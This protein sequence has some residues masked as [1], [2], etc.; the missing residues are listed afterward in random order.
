[1][2]RSPRNAWGTSAPPTSTRLRVPSPPWVKPRAALREWEREN[3][4]S[5]T[6]DVTVVGSGPNGL[7]A[8][9]TAARAGLSV[10]VLEASD[11]VGGGL[12]TAELT[13]PGFRHDVCS[14]VHPAVAS[15]P[16]F[17][18]TGIADRVEWVVPEAS[19][20]HPFDDGSAGIAWR[21]L[22]RTADALGRDGAAWRRMLA[23]LARDIDGVVDFTGNPL[24]R[25]PRHPV[26]A[27]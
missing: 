12:R 13:L 14:A 26:T 17:R 22:E 5:R 18:E 4:M 9:V 21:D 2:P 20:A 25:V 10:V 15:S 24:L 11:T 6:P 16:F 1:M 23:P 7:A 3:P 19:Y 27:A 8:A